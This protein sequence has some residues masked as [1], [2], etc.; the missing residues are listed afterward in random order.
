MEHRWS[1]RQSFTT[2]SAM[3]DCPVVGIGKVSVRNMSLGGAFVETDLL[4]LPL[5][6]PV[7][8]G[9]GLCGGE[10]SDDFMVEAMVVR[11][12]AD[13][14]A[15]MFLEMEDEVARVLQGALC[16]SSQPRTIAPESSRSVSQSGLRAVTI[17]GR[18]RNSNRM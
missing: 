15:L 5:Y 7:F 13:G 16:G 8:V 10:R 1:V 2:T 6:A 12:A 11:R 9:F 4:V 3:V 18:I 14:A 17:A